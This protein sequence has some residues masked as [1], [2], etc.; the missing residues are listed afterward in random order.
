MRVAEMELQRYR[1]EA[2]RD[3]ILHRKNCVIRYEGILVIAVIFLFL[4]QSRRSI[5]GTVKNWGFSKF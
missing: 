4:Y 2:E 5:R 3:A 1:T